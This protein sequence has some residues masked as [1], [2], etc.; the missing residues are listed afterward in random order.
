MKINLNFR[1][2]RFASPLWNDRS[3][4]RQELFSTERLEQHA[5]SLAA[6]QPVSGKAPRVTSLHKRL[7]DNA[8]VLLSAYRAS[9]AELKNG[10]EVV[11]AA[12]WLLDNYHL[13]EKQIQEIRDDL[14][15]GYYRQLP[16]LADGP[17]AGYP[18]VLE[19]AWAFVA[20]T[21][22]LFDRDKL[23]RFLMAYQQ[24][25]H[26]TIGELWA[27]AITLRFVLVENLRRLADQISAGGAARAE[28]S[29][30]SKKLLDQE[31]EEAAFAVSIAA[32]PQAPFP[33]SLPRIWPSSCETGTPRR[34]LRSH[35]W[36]KLAQQ[37]S[38]IDEVVQ[39]SQQRQ[40]ASN[41]TVRNIITS[42]R[43]ISDID[44]TEMF[45]SVSPVDA[46]MRQASPFED[47]DFPTRD[48]YRTAI[49]QLARGSSLTE[50]EVTEQALDAARETASGQSDA[51]EIARSSDPGYHLI[52]EG[53]PA[54]E[55][56]IG[57]RP[58]ARLW[59]ARLNLRLGIAGYIGSSLIVTALLMAL[60][61]LLLSRTGLEAGWL[62]MFAVL[63]FLPACEVATAVVNRA[64]S[65]C[66]GAT[67]LPGLSLRQGVPP[68]L[69]TLV[70]I[71]TLLT[72]E[73]DILEQIERL[74]IHHLSGIGGDIVFA[75]VTDGS[76]ADQEN[77]DSDKRLLSVASDAIAR[78][79]KHHEPVNGTNRFLLLHRRRLF[80]AKEG[81]WMGWERKRGKLHELNRLL[82]GA[83][84][85]S[86]TP[87]AG[88]PIQVPADVRY[89]IT[90]DADTRLPRDAAHRLIGK[91]AHP[92][93]RPRFSEA[94]QRIV[95]GYGILQP[96]VT[97][98]LPVGHEGSLYQRAF[99]APGGI[100]PYA[101]A[102]S[103]VYQDLFGVGAY[104]GK[105]IYDIDAFEST[106]SGRVADNAMLSHDLFEGAF[107]RAGLASD[108]EVIEEFPARYDVDARRQHRWTRGD[109]QLLPW[110]TGQERKH[111]TVPAVGRGM[112]LDN[113]K[114]SL[115]APLTVLA[116]G[117][118]WLMPLPAALMATAL[119]LAAMAIPAFLPILFNV[120]PQNRGIHVG[121]HLATLGADLRL[122]ALRTGLD[123]VFLPDRAWRMTDAIARTLARLYLTRRHLLEWTTS[124][125]SQGSPRLDASGFYRRMAPGT[126]IG[127]AIALAAG[128]LNPSSFLLVLPFAVLWLS[129]PAIALWISRPPAEG[130][131]PAISDQQADELR[132]I[133]RRTWR[134]FETFVTHQSNML[135]PDN[136]QED[137]R[138]VIARRTSP[139]NIGLYLLSA[140]AAH[141]F[142]WA[143]KVETVER[144]EAT[145]K[146]MTALSKHRGHFFN[147]YATDDMR[148][149]DPAY[150]SS[151]DSGNLAG[152]LI[153]LANACEAWAEADDVSNVRTGMKDSLALAR[154]A[155]DA[156]AG[157]GQQADEQLTPVL[158]DIEARLNGSQTFETFAPML[159]RLAEKAA[160]IAREMVPRIRENACAD[161]IFWLEALKKRIAEDRRD[162]LED[163]GLELRLGVVASEA[164]AMA[165]AMDFA[166]LL[167]PERKLLSIGYSLADNNLDA[168][169]YDLL[170]SE[171]RLASLFAIAKG[172][173]ETRHWF[174]LG[175]SATPISGASALISWSGSM[176]EYLMPSLSCVPPKAACSRRPT[177][178]WSGASKPMRT[179]SARHGAFLNPP[180][181]PAT[182]S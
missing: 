110:L 168:N 60:S 117:L 90:L 13:V 177:D 46:R 158:D 51:I 67:I 72:S 139:T 109:W 119:L 145:L 159:M 70:A 107:A 65:W 172:D 118:A 43:L 87:I 16:K 53:R 6:A 35:G 103:N 125:Q 84:D 73:A 96:R 150:V 75:L 98:S 157:S 167:D 102:A 101:A 19:L 24:V 134:F 89:V 2:A 114:R 166:F 26:L 12:E 21:D 69:R 131:G 154:E 104:T 146:T 4:V 29:A 137:P 17:F 163:N 133:A 169:C 57:F 160:T 79:N 144:L 174:L 141:D 136:F 165:M 3:P 176:F 94:E 170:A 27:V 9:I 42:I 44:W 100:D 181:T 130:A 58:P 52:S 156:I 120:I 36:K 45:E 135:P 59:L 173:I 30:L 50:L 105:G 153:A 155:L 151:V 86:F 147:W 116:F 34:H 61:L 8:V 129:A 15:P 171:A 148:V 182:R 143:G 91:M 127:L 175:R 18:R 7:S 152:H 11:P 23:K 48:L 121:S 180:T 78:L 40:G 164:R 95:D 71:P 93:N 138:P 80:N 82:R 1:G 62:A 161:L 56:A 5:I 85:T 28:A 14:P 41:V 64:M 99:S 162:R 123:I 66:F 126:L 32:R 49:E 31:T 81:K 179:H 115:A 92:L 22:S 149:L 10:R 88:S 108:V 124:A 142:G 47:M 39:H 128:L 83:D 76:D 38:S 113:L 33:S 74:E 54:L 112:M 140:V 25:Q 20:H 106:L 97:P 55:R 122:A 37:G 68:S 111:G 178:W 63:G 132:L 77:I